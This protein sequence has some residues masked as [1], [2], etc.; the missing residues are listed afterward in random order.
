MD[1]RTSKRQPR[2]RGSV[3][4]VQF[5]PFPPDLHEPPQNCGNALHPSCSCYSWTLRNENPKP[6]S[7]ELSANYI[8]HTLPHAARTVP[9]LVRKCLCVSAKPPEIPQSLAP[10]AEN[11]LHTQP[12]TSPALAALPCPLQRAKVGGHV[13][14]SSCPSMRGGSVTAAQRNKELTCDMFPA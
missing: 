4:T 2:H 1:L 12:L 6:V 3:T 14:F 10:S 13:G 8:S 9:C 11:A 7:P 5:L